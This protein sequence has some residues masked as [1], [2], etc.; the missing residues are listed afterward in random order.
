M[1]G[2]AKIGTGRFEPENTHYPVWFVA[3]VAVVVFERLVLNGTA[4]LL[5]L[6]T[7]GAIA[8]FGKAFAFLDL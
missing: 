5:S 2:K 8:L 1:T 6:M 4:E 3:G 7:F